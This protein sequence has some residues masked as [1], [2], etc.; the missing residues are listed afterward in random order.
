MRITVTG[1]NINL[2]EG[3][4]EAV[5]EKLSKLEKYFASETVLPDISIPSIYIPL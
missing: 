3:I 2:T 4:K 1:R 5:E